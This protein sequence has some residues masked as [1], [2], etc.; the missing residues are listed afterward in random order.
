MA[1]FVMQLVTRAIYQL[2]TTQF[3]TGTLAL[4]VLNFLT[5]Y[6]SADYVRLSIHTG[7]DLAPLGILSPV[8]GPIVELIGSS[9][10]ST[11]RKFRVPPF[12][13]SIDLE[14]PDTIL[15]ELA[16][17]LMATIFGAIHCMAWFF[18]ATLSQHSAQSN[19]LNHISDSQVRR[20]RDAL[21]HTYYR[22]RLCQETKL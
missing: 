2:E 6:T 12:D 22:N 4:A 7:D 16:A 11:S 20:S 18:A 5:Y 9:K 13:G 1:W 21:G 17:L 8:L 19:I 10:I 15:L 14:Y 3:E